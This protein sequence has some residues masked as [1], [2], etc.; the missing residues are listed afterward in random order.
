MTRVIVELARVEGAHLAGLVGQFADVLD[1]SDERS[2]ADP[3][4]MRLVPDAYADRDAAEE[5]RRLTESDLLGR[6]RSDAAVVL[7]SLGS[8]GELPDDPG[9]P[10]LVEMIRVRLDEEQA[11]AWL[12][13]LAAIRLVL[14]TR[15]GIDKDDDHDDGDPRFGIYDWLGY[16][17]D[18]LVQALDGA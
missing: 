7:E 11:Q 14:A 5:F 10:A 18:G 8:V 17:L 2:N 9:D 1:A 16:R 6:R 4:V 12:R 13:T 3:A 15:L